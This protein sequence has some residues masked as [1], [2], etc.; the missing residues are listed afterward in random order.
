MHKQLC[1]IVALAVVSL[2]SASIRTPS[3][4]HDAV[5]SA[6]VQPGA[7]RSLGAEPARPPLDVPAMRQI[8]GDGIFSALAG[9]IIGFVAGGPTGAVIGFGI[10]YQFDV[11]DDLGGCGYTSDGDGPFCET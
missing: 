11:V 8:H 5:L 10:G 2:G 7:P 9:A 1:A 3:V 6:S 4:R